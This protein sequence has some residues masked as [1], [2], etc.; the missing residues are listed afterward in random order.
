MRRFFNYLR[1]HRRRWQLTQAELGFLFGYEQSTIAR[2]EGDEHALT[3][4]VA[5]ACELIFGVESTDIFPSLFERVEERVAHRVRKLMEQLSEAE[6][7]NLAS[8]KLEL[9]RG[10]L[11]RIGAVPPQE[12]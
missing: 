6:A 1:T 7:A 4:D 5:Y 8:P 11:G 10:A 3:L 2:L 12:I 9:L